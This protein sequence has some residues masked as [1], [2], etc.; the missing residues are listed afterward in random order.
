MFLPSLLGLYCSFFVD[1]MWIGLGLCCSLLTHTP[2]PGPVP[3]IPGSRHFP[4]IPSSTPPI[5]QSSPL[6]STTPVPRS[7]SLS[8]LLPLPSPIYSSSIHSAYLHILLPLRL[9]QY[10]PLSATPLVPIYSSFIHSS[11]PPFLAGKQ[12]RT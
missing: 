3:C 1:S 12:R 8:S 5:P 2:S 7:T 6:T 10:T 4:D 9:S 11:C